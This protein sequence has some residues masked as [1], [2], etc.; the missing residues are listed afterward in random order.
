MDV[1]K[2]L[3]RLNSGEKL[4]EAELD[5]VVRLLRGMLDS[6]EDFRDLGVD[7][8]YE[9]LTV[10]TRAKAHQH[11]SLLERFFD[12]KDPLT[13][14]L[15]LEALCLD[16]GWI[17]E[18]LERVINFALGVSWDAEQDIR[19][20]AI[21]ILGEYLFRL[22][23]AGSSPQAREIMQLLLD[24]V[25]DEELNHWTR[26]AAYLALCRAAGKDWEE[27]PPE[28]RKLDFSAGSADIDATVL[29]YSR[30]F[31]SSGSSSGVASA[32]SREAPVTR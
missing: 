30:D 26:K 6:P 15:V 11:R 8:A 29:A 13:V 1:E 31:V 7:D 17:E 22:R 18:Y 10:L 16:W 4:K 20:C 5:E 28:Y 25:G 27:L 3:V 19:H 24:A 9:L 21:K 14:T 2:M 23:S 32:T 12:D